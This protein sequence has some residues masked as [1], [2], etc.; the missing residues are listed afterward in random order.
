MKKI[1]L[2]FCPRCGQ[3]LVKSDLKSYKY[4]CKNCDENFYNIEVIYKK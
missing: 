3:K 4:L 1:K 2:A